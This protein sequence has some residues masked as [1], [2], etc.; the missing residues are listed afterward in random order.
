MVGYKCEKNRLIYYLLLLV[1]S[2][3]IMCTVLIGFYMYL[4]QFAYKIKLPFWKTII[5][6]SVILLLVVI[7]FFTYKNEVEKDE[8][9]KN[10]KK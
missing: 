2:I 1:I 8:N 5:T 6:C 7:V 3:L 9:E 4:I 10:K